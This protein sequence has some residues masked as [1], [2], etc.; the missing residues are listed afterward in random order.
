MAALDA[1]Q[2]QELSR[3]VGDPDELL[4]AR[5]GAAKLV[6]RDH[7]IGR[8]EQQRSEASQ[9]SPQIGQLTLMPMQDRT[10]E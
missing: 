4:V 1:A 8:N 10:S 6:D 2:D 9:G 5:K 3:V 7:G